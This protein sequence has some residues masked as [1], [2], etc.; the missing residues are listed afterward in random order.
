[1]KTF[2]IVKSETKYPYIKEK[3]AINEK[4]ND[5][6]TKNLYLFIKFFS[7]LNKLNVW[8]VANN[9]VKYNDVFPTIFNKPLKFAAWS[10]DEKILGVLKNGLL[11]LQGIDMLE[12]DIKKLIDEY[13]WNNI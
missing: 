13:T 5:P 3:K 1:M 2:N 8:N 9:K 11:D 6:K 7:V 4:I 10:F 12:Y